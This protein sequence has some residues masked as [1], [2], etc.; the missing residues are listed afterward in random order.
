MESDA[1]ISACGAYRYRLQRRWADGDLLGYIML[2]PSIADA[3]VDDPTIRRCMSFAMGHGF[4][5][6]R[7]V[8]LFALR[9]TNPAE[10]I[11]PEDPVGPDN[12]RHLVEMAAL[13]K[14]GARVVAA[15]GVPKNNLVFERAI[16]VAGWF[17]SGLHA[18]GVSRDGHPRHPLYLAA[19]SGLRPWQYACNEGGR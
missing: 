7:V 15:W 8:N 1:M 10:L 4:G 11:G 12:D 6:I 13:A 5:G 19:T 16:R 3:T 9:A 18:L 14:H 2:N 17:G